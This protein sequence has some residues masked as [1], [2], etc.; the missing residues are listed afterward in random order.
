ME[1]A[2]PCGKNLD[3]ME[4]RYAIERSRGRMRAHAYFSGCSARSLSNGCSDPS[5]TPFNMVVLN[6]MSRYQLAAEALRRVERVFPKAGPLILECQNAVESA[7][8]YSRMYLEDP[9][10]IQNWTWTDLGI[11][12]RCDRTPEA[13]R[14][15]W[16]R[17]AV[18]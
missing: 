2:R 11:R 7:V 5:T 18:S 12:G 1:K 16:F 4:P 8:S 6:G 13:G 3:R 15:V 10:D 14:L 17:R 9:P